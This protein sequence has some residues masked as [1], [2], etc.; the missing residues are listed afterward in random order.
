MMKLAVLLA[1]VGAALTAPQE[2]FGVRRTPET[3]GV[4]PSDTDPTTDDFPLVIFD[5]PFFT[6]VSFPSFDS[7]GFPGFDVDLP[8]DLPPNYDN[9]THEVKVVNGSRVEVNSTISKTTHEGGVVVVHTHIVRKLP[10]DSGTEDSVP[11]AGDDAQ[12][13]AAGE[14]EQPAEGEAAEQPNVA[15]NQV[16]P[17][18]DF[19]F[20]SRVPT[21]R[22]RRWILNWLSNTFKRSPSPINTNTLDDNTH[23]YH[24]NNQYDNTLFGNTHHDNTHHDNTLFDNT[25]HDNT[26]FGNTHHDNTLELPNDKDAYE[27]NPEPVPEVAREFETAHDEAFTPTSNDIIPIRNHDDIAVNYIGAFPRPANPDA[28]IF[29]ID[30]IRENERQFFEGRSQPIRSQPLMSQPIRS[31]PLMSQP[32]RSEPI[33]SQPMRSQPIMSQSMRSQPIM[34]QSMLSEPIMSQ[35]MRSQPIRSQPIRL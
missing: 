33:M 32:M 9:S 27:F 21:S 20:V 15:D 26:L 11:T 2:L 23:R 7:D 5:V 25:H 31:Q 16:Q 13:P 14:N 17:Y 6:D 29:D 12:E 8:S 24:H 30:L 28:E 19:G 10:E 35:P 22:N 34:S 1:M 3:E 4:A 18:E